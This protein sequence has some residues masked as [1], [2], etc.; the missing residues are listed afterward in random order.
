[1]NMATQTDRYISFCGIEC[2]QQ[3]YTLMA[4]IESHLKAGKGDERWRAYFTE[5][6]AQK[7]RMNHDHLFFIG[8]QMNNLY[9]YL[10]SSADEAGKEMLWRIEQECC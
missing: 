3:A 7:A 9:D 8:A 2:D 4:R 5:K 6:L 1:M 10:E